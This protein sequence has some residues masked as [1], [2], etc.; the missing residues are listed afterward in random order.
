MSDPI[1]IEFPTIAEAIGHLYTGQVIQVYLGE[2]GGTTNYADYDVD[3]KIYVEGTV[4]WARGNVVMLRCIVRTNA[5]KDYPKDLLIN[6]FTISSVMKKG[7]D[8]ITIS[9][10]MRGT[11]R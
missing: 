5:G 3:Q 4:L 7:D 10:I 2:S 1:P 9:H 11:K 6:T 8:G